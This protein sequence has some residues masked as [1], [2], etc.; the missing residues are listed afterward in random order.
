MSKPRWLEQPEIQNLLHRIVDKLDKADGRP[1]RT[2]KLNQ[3]SFPE[4]FNADFEG[5]K[6]NYWSQL[7]ELNQ[8]GWFSIKTDRSESGS[9]GYDLNPKLKI[10][11]ETAIR[12]AIGRLEPI[13]SS[14]QIWREAV[15]RRLQLNEEQLEVIAN[16]KIEIPGKSS[17][18]IVERLN[19]LVNLINEP[20]LLREVS[21]RLFWGHSK[22]LDRRQELIAI[23]LGVVDCPFPETPIQLQVY[24]PAAQFN[25]V[26]F[27]ENLTSFER[28]TRDQTDRF[29]NLA[30]IFAS[31]FMS[32]AKRLR[33]QN[34]CSIYFA[35]HGSLATEDTKRI[36]AWLATDA[37][38]LPVWF[39]GDLDYAGMQILKTLRNSF[40]ELEAWQPG[41]QPMMEALLSGEGHE[42]D[43]ANKTNQKYVEIT[44]SMYADTALIPTM[45]RTGKFLDQE[46]G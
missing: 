1:V 7:I 45:N 2:F 13:K 9:V 19:L 46:F 10:T 36:L 29:A 21:A 12:E 17:D 3:K 25:G 22:V 16:Q 28:A 6:E 24:L 40:P 14:Q 11:D 35:G 32:S 44:G 18:E 23:A 41:Y 26:L 8:W 39:W 27:I 43:E 42:P 20:L 38:R 15:Y 34:G 37:E 33:S 30:L 31:G 4:L 5:D